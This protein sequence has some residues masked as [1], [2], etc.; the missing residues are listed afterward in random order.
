MHAI[1]KPNRRKRLTTELAV[2]A[3]VSKIDEKKNQDQKTLA[4][5]KR[6]T[7]KKKEKK[8][9]KNP[10]Q[11]YMRRKGY[12]DDMFPGS[13]EPMQKVMKETP[14]YAFDACEQ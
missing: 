11:I 12:V 5:N 8:R 3:V 14:R 1:Q 10:V 4:V 13:S 6:N 7:H 9:K 2:E